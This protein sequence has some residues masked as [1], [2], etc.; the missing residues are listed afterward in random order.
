LAWGP[1]ENF[2]RKQKGFGGACG[3]RQKATETGSGGGE[4]TPLPWNKILAGAKQQQM[5]KKLSGRREERGEIQAGKPGGSWQGGGR[6]G[7]KKKNRKTKHSNGRAKPGRMETKG[8]HVGKTGASTEGKGPPVIWGKKENGMATRGVTLHRKASK[9]QKK[10]RRSAWHGGGRCAAGKKQEI[11]RRTKNLKPCPRCLGVKEKSPN[12]PR[13]KKGGENEKTACASKREE[14]PKRPKKKRIT[15]HEV[16]QR[17]G[18][19]KETNLRRKKH[20]VART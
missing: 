20:G 11:E 1:T 19:Q 13:E 12:S 18:A 3:Q 6:G 2:C 9:A 5:T 8:G 4:H 16:Q 7:G 10:R 15:R 17:G 14:R